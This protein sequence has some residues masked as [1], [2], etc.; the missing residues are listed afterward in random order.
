MSKTRTRQVSS[1][2]RRAGLF[3]ATRVLVGR[4]VE[5]RSSARHG[6]SLLGRQ[7][8]NETEVYR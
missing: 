8:M 6:G 1:V 4:H 2:Q 3:E 5:M 7:R